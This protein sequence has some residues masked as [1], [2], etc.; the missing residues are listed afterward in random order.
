[1]IV[2]HGPPGK[3]LVVRVGIRDAASTIPTKTAWRGERGERERERERERR[4]E[5]PGRSGSEK[6]PGERCIGA[7]SLGVDRSKSISH[8]FAHAISH[9]RLDVT[10]LQV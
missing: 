7:Q 3:W 5:N 10:Y 6:E 9:E 4:G 1:M 8:L 2:H